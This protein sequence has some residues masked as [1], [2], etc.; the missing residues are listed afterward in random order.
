LFQSLGDTF[1]VGISTLYLIVADQCLKWQ[2]VAGG[3]GLKARRR[4]RDAVGVE[5]VGNGEGETPSPSD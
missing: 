4:D 3:R 5:G 1:A 2:R